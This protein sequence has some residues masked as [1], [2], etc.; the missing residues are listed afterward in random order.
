MKHFVLFKTIWHSR[1]TK[2]NLILK[3]NQIPNETKYKR[4]SKQIN[5]LIF[6]FSLW[7]LLHTFPC[8]QY[9]FRVCLKVF[10]QF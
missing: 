10:E 3:R 1:E 2:N 7:L 8:N 6:S 4:I 5:K 9:D